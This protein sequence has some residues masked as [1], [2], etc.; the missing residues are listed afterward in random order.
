MAKRV[1]ALKQSGFSPEAS[2]GRVLRKLRESRQLSQEELGFK[3]GYHRTYIGQ[4]ERGEKSPSMRA[5]FNLSETLGIPASQI[6]RRVERSL[7]GIGRQVGRSTST[8]P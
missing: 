4:L 7:R 2:F 6:V 8:R 3:S 5:L 1:A